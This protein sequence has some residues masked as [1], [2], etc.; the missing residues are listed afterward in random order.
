MKH[1]KLN[2]RRNLIASLF[3][4]DLYKKDRELAFPV[5]NEQIK[6]LTNGECYLKSTQTGFDLY[7]QKNS[8]FEVVNYGVTLYVH[9]S[10]Y[11][12]TEV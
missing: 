4:G 12:I 9:K 2:K 6:N 1:Y 11:Y 7:T 10:E 3:I 5:V 8:N